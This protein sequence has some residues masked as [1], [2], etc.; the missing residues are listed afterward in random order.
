MCFGS[1][2]NTSGFFV[3]NQHVTYLKKKIIKIYEK[4][5]QIY[6]QVS[7]IIY[8]FTSSNKQIQIL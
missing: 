1:P 4:K 7:E 6:L 8:T 2:G 5:V 3:Y